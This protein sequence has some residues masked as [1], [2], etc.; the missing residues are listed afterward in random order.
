MY[1][2]VRV[3]SNPSKP[4]ARRL[5]RKEVALI[6][7]FASS[8]ALL[9]FALWRLLSPPQHTADS[10]VVVDDQRGTVVLNVSV[11]LLPAPAPTHDAGTD[12]GSAARPKPKPPPA[13]L[14][15]P[16]SDAK[17]VVFSERPDELYVEVHRGRTNEVGQL[18]IEGL[19]PGRVWVLAEAPGASRVSRTLLLRDTHEL[20]LDLEPAS[21][22][23]VTVL[24]D[25]RQPIPQATVLVSDDDA[26]PFGALTIESGAA[27]FERLGSGPYRVR[28]FARGYE[29]ADRV[30]VTDDL[31]VVLRKLGGLDIVVRDSKLQPAADADVY[32]VGSSLWPARRVRTNEQGEARLD[33]LL[34]GIY[35]LR[36]RRGTAVSPVVS[37]VQLERGQRQPVELVLGVGRSLQVLAT[38]EKP[39]SRP[40]EGASVVVAE[41]GLSPFPLTAKTNAQGQAWVGPLSP[42]PAFVSVRAKGYVGRA[43]LPIPDDPQQVLHV[44]LRAGG[45]LRGKVV[46]VHGHAI[47]GARV[48]VIGFDQDGLPIAETPLI[49]AY[50]DAHFDFAM[51]PIP[52]VPAGEL[53]ITLGHVPYVNEAHANTGWTQLPEDYSPWISDVEGRFNAH[54][55]PPGRVR[56]LVRHPGYVE[57]LSEVVELGAGGEQE[58]TVTLLEGARLVGR[59]VDT[60]GFPV[61]DARISIAALRGSFERS[62]LSERDGMFRL[63]AVPS[64]VVISLARPED[65]TRYVWRGE[66]KLRGG[67]ER[68]IEFEL[69]DARDSAHWHVH[70]PD[71]RPIEL[72]QVTLTSLVTE[73]PMRLTQ[74]TAEAGDVRFDDI[75]GLHVRVSVQAPGF[76][77]ISEELRKAPVERTFTLSR[78]V[79][80]EGKVTAVRGLREAAGARVELSSVVG[81]KQS[82]LTDGR[83]RYTF[84]RVPLGPVRLRVEHE[85]HASVERRFVVE[86]TGRADRAFEFEDID[87]PEGATVE[88][89]VLDADGEPVARARVGLGQV[90]AVLARGALPENMVHSDEK[91]AFTLRGIAP[92]KVEI[93]AVSSVKGRGSTRLEIDGGDHLTDIEITLQPPDSAPE[94]SL[95]S[96]GV[97]FTLGERDV[98]GG[99]RVVVVSVSPHGEAERAGLLA[100]DIILSVDGTRAR[101]MTQTR[102]LTNGK[103]G[104][105]VVIEVERS[106]QRHSYRVRRES[107]SQ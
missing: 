66:V 75:A 22:L 17:V 86:D 39:N 20:T 104:S 15:T 62:L 65:P 73:V 30:E 24:D 53:G 97:A 14:A 89:R 58:V 85:Q 98:S 13:A 56:A 90:A 105:D 46:D 84:S 23:E 79:D 50:R 77:P 81:G 99:V 101:T 60:R 54:P 102:T 107:L 87:L 74:F 1:S 95:E 44:I 49:A 18:T 51:K 100:G 106:G 91:G 96:G 68:E 37:A 35:D 82:T 32:V 76:V 26:L 40:I 4:P 25:E 8:L 64:E 9:V 72:A 27:L 36:A 94:I 55:V 93:G 67:E 42:G 31:T 48:E 92:G 41:F 19:Q 5:G 3:P 88:G 7:L 28:V 83:G 45:R 11:N 33:G 6:L 47:A 69:P 2:A 78:G 38:G 16:V 57:A 34:S 70:D 59:V 63:A 29:A 21:R 103:S 43:A 80:V 12:A 71:G 10:I 52:L 61:A